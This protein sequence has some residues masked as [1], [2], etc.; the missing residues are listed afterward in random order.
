[1]LLNSPGTTTSVSAGTSA[2][3]GADDDDD[4][5]DVS[6]ASSIDIIGFADAVRTPKNVDA[7]IRRT[8]ASSRSVDFDEKN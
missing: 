2:T 6:E 1:M 8:N 7:C 5:D 3:S 4:D